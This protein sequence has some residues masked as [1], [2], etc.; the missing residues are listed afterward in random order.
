MYVITGATGNT[1]SIIANALL[2]KGE[3]VRVIGRSAGRLQTLISRGA[4]PFV[5]DVTD[6]PSLT[7][8]FGDAQA[9]YAIVPPDMQA[10]D[11]CA[12]QERITDALAAALEKSAV[13]YA[14]SLSSVGADKPDKTGPVAGLHSL[15]EKFNSIAALNVLHLRAGYF[16]EN[17]LPQ[18]GVITTM[19][20][21]AGPLRGELKL[22][23]IATHDV[24]TYAAERLLLLDFNGKQTRELLGQRDLS[25]NEAASIV[26]RAVGKPGLEYVQVP[27]EQLKPTLMQMGMSANVADLL[28]EMAAALNS[29]HMRSLEPR[30][31]VNTT[32]TSFER[33]VAEVFVPVYQEQSRAA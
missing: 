13:K 11:Y 33:F 25:M 22:P 23:M 7:R 5:C 17:T 26:G 27:D 16:M 4:E 12:Q 15:E 31:D 30:S 24:G 8:A 3:K 2:D 29:G 18:A 28:L 9:V 19:G 10:E 32:P 14:V 20:I 1:G 21:M 6:A